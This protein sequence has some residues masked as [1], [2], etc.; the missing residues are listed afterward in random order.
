MHTKYTKVHLYRQQILVGLN[1]KVKV[2][3]KAA[4]NIRLAQVAIFEISH[5][6]LKWIPLFE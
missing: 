4:E 5:E 1:V 2:E 3:V 6:L